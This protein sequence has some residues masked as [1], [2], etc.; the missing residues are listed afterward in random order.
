MKRKSISHVNSVD[1]CTQRVLEEWQKLSERIAKVPQDDFEKW[2]F[3]SPFSWQYREG[4][5]PTFTSDTAEPN[6]RIYPCEELH[7]GS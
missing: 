4:Y 5:A 3:K 6:K 2:N 7:L 1:D